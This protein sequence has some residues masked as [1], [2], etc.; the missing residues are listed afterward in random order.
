MFPASGAL[1][2]DLCG[3]IIQPG[4]LF[5]LGASVFRHQLRTR[6]S[7]G[8][9]EWVSLL[10]GFKGG[11]KLWKEAPFK[12]GGELLVVVGFGLQPLNHGR[13]VV[14]TLLI[15]KRGDSLGLNPQFARL[16]VKL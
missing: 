4:S 6:R 1:L 9:V 10:P 2:E 5:R 11:T 13:S 7:I 3:L 12:K 14:Q 8:V 16:A 15:G